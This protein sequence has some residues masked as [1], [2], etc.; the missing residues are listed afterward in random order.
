MSTPDVQIEDNIER[1]F[2]ITAFWK[3]REIKLHSAT[4]VKYCY[5]WFG[6]P[7]SGSFL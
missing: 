7:S 6:V 4:I 5:K 2:F 1:L 3:Y